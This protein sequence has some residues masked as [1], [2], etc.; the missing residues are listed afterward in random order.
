MGDHCLHN[1]TE[2]KIW[3]KTITLLTITS[4][5]KMITPTTADATAFIIDQKVECSAITSSLST[6]VYLMTIPCIPKDFLRVHQ[7]TSVVTDNHKWLKQVI[8]S[9]SYNLVYSMP[10]TILI[11]VDVLEDVVTITFYAFVKQEYFWFEI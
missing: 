3:N 4:D 9:F 7:F 10:I 1:E 2:F 5:V 8:Y 6:R 11:K